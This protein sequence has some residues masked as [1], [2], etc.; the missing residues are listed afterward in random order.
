MS[1][2]TISDPTRS[3]ISS[4]VSA[5]GP[6]RFDAP[7]GPTADPSGPEAAHASLSA[8]QAK[9]AGLLTSGTYG[10][11][12]TGSSA[13]AVL[14]SSLVSRLRAR[15]A[16][17]G[18]TLYKLTWKERVTPAGRSISALRASARPTSGN[19][20][21]G[22][23]SEASAWPTPTTRDWK[24]GSF[25]PNVPENALLGRAVWQAGWPTT[26]TTDALRHPSPSFTTPNVTLNHAAVLAGWGTPNASAPGGTPEQA[27]KRKE[28]RACGQSVTTL[29]HQVQ[30]SG[31]PTPTA[32]LADKGVRTHAGAIIEAMRNKGPDLGAVT[33][34][35]GPARRTV[36]GEMLTGS[37]AGMESGGQLNPAHSRW[38]M[39]L[40]PEWDACAATATRSTRKLRSPSSPA[41]T[42]EWMLA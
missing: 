1:D 5:S 21:G 37:S 31:W 40:P 34:L 41:L 23:E 15:T 26:T 16:S 11:T 29:D 12:S 7:N 19:G 36:S 3:A 17:L 35:A 33:A 4:P 38:L 6:M 30:L 25:N 2:L 32:A 8:R 39:G 18:S 20:S 27:L 24:D 42:A 22:S 14:T 9:A 28:G 13:S 10:H